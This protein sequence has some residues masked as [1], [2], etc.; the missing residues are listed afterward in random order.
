MSALS[1]KPRRAITAAA[2]TAIALYVAIAGTMFAVQRRLLFMPDTSK[3]SAS[4]VGLPSLHEVWITGPTGRRLLAWY[5]PPDQGQL[6]LAY[7]HGNGGN[8]GDRRDRLRRYAAQGWGVLMPEYPGYGGNSGSPS[9]QGFVDAAQ[10]A[11]GFL[12]SSQGID[13]HRIA[14]YGESIGTA[15]ATRVAAEHPIGALILESPFTSVT[16]I[17]QR[18]YPFLPISLLLRDRFDQLSRIGAIRCPL[19]VLQGAQDTIVPPDLGQALF[20]AAPQ[21]K[22]LWVAPDAGHQNLTSFG[23]TE[24]VIGFLERIR[25]AR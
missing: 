6:V 19:L 22:T 23:A 17:A 3:P 10:G 8:L 2:L 5:I 20:D 16:A 14:V 13:P 11:M 18:R 21:P 9:E 15:V 12:A 24:V 7:F 4:A 1:S 25:Q